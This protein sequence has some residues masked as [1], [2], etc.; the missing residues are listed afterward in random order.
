MQ[1]SCPLHEAV[2]TVEQLEKEQ[3]TLV[4]GRVRDVLCPPPG[5]RRLL[6]AGIGVAIFQQA[7]GC[8]VGPAGGTEGGDTGA[9]ALTDGSPLCLLFDQASRRL[10]TTCPRWVATRVPDAAACRRHGAVVCTHAHAPSRRRHGAHGLSCRTHGAGACTVWVA[11]AFIPGAVILC[12]LVLHRCS[13]T[14]AWNRATISCSPISASA[15]ARWAHTCEAQRQ[16]KPVQQPQS[17]VLCPSARACLF[18][19][20]STTQTLFIFVAM[21]LTDRVGRRTVRRLPRREQGRARRSDRA[22]FHPHHRP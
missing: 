13:K 8:W 20:L 9:P 6:L 7:S 14:P 4:Q 18:I 16:R 19:P 2:D 17:P 1:R 3:Q 21:G 10:S 11:T 15:F 12:L 22:P 5:T